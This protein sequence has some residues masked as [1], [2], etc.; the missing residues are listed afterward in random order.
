M[1]IIKDIS[2]QLREA[3]RLMTR[4]PAL[5]AYAAISDILFILIFAFFSSAIYGKML[6]YAIAAS[7][8][9]AKSSAELGSIVAVSQTFYQAFMSID[10]VNLF[11]YD[12]LIMMFI[13]LV[14]AYVFYCFFQ[15]ISWHIAGK[16]S[17]RRRS[18]YRFIASFFKINIVWIIIYS[19]FSI[20]RLTAGFRE[21][22]STRPYIGNML[23]MGF[24]IPALGIIIIYFAAVSYS[25][26]F[27]GKKK[28]IASTISVG[29]R[30][31]RGLIP[32][33]IAI[34]LIIALIH[35]I[36]VLIFRYSV[37]ASGIFFIAAELPSLTFARIVM[38]RIMEDKNEKKTE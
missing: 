17:G 6:E 31:F 5:I 20:I 18:Y 36:Q 19:V 15:A 30:N 29:Y 33:Y 7:S 38:I 9:A 22:I 24:L 3:F 37:I 8:L 35:A 12:I 11:V 2:G 1:K 10:G 4:K 27:F 34:A 14:G 21:Q 13:L 16:I 32:G 25:S 26:L 28:S 23:D